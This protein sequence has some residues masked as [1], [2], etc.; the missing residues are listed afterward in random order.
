MQ[1]FP[2]LLR[3][4]SKHQVDQQTK[5]EKNGKES[6]RDPR[7]SREFGYSICVCADCCCICGCHLPLLVAYNLHRDGQLTIASA[8]PNPWFCNEPSLYFAY[9][10]NFAS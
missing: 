8:A 6:N 2:H 7:Q 10:A 5:R 1:L 9:R 4:D 3:T